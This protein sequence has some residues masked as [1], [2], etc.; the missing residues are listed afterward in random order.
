MSSPGVICNLDGTPWYLYAQ[1]RNLNQV[2]RFSFSAGLKTLESVGFVS[3]LLPEIQS[4]LPD[5]RSTGDV[6]EGAGKSVPSKIAN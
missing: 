1:C 5:V 3:G 2:G 4:F 6:K